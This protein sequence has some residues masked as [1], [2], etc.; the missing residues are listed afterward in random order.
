MNGNWRR[1]LAAVVIILIVALPA[2]EAAPSPNAASDLRVLLNAMFSEHVWLAASATGAALAGRQREFE[3]AAAAL[4]ANSNDLI[5]AMGLIYGQPAQKAFG[6]GWKQH[7]ASVVEYTKARAAKDAA[8]QQKAR[9]DLFLYSHQVGVFLNAATKTL[10][11][12]VV[13]ALVKS[14]ITTLTAVIDAQ[15]AGDHAEAYRHLRAAA[16]HVHKIADPL[17]DAIARQFPDKFGR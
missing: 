3:S 10:P 5:K 17:A 13:E 6:A 2:A 4:D 16:G 14:H 1:G 11:T 7:I 9:K 15:A 8:K 12:D